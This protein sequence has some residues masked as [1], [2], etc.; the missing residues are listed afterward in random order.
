[1]LATLTN[2]KFSVPENPVM[3]AVTGF[4]VLQ[5][6]NGWAMGQ[7]VDI[8]NSNGASGNG[9]FSGQASG[10]NSPVQTVAPSGGLI[11][12]GGGD[13]SPYTAD[14]CNRIIQGGAASDADKFQCSIRGF[15]GA[16]PVAFVPP[17]LVPAPPTSVTIPQAIRRVNQPR[18]MPVKVNRCG[19]SAPVEDNS[20]AIL[21]GLGA[22]LIGWFAFGGS[23]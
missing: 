12:Q 5:P 16:T 19:A 20:S 18:P 13:G 21:I 2:G 6:G 23:K 17:V 10:G 8:T 15:I 4:G 11:W 7:A 22:L 9:L 1:M 14:Y 3:R